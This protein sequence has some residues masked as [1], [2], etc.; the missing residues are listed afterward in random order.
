MLNILIDSNVILDVMMIREPFFEMS[1]RIITLA[2]NNSINA[3]ISAASVTDIYYIA[4]RQ[5]RDKNVVLNL[6]KNL[7]KVVKVAAVTE[8]EI[9]AALNLSWR[10]FEDAVQYSVAKSNDMDY[11][12]TRNTED[13]I[14]SDIPAITP[15]DFCRI[16][17][18]E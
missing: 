4:R 14:A 11:I 16:L 18:E 17:L 2:E 10:D 1:K 13:F 9:D 6:I 12:I 15:E 8:K 7:R 5:L 3:Y